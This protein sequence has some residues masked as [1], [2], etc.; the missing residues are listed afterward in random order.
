MKDVLKIVQEEFYS[1]LEQEEGITKKDLELV[2]LSIAFSPVIQFN[3]DKPVE[4]T[5]TI[6]GKYIVHG[7]IPQTVDA[8]MLTVMRYRFLIN[9]TNPFR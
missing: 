1:Q 2:D 6:G 8:E 3:G 5:E 7:Q 4:V 9:R